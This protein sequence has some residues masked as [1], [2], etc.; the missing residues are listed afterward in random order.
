MGE[1][2]NGLF[3]STYSPACWSVRCQLWVGI[4]PSWQASS[5]P[6]IA[7][8][9]CGPPRHPTHS[10]TRPAHPPGWSCTR[11]ITPD[12]AQDIYGKKVICHCFCTVFVLVNLSETHTCL[13]W[14]LGEQHLILGHPEFLSEAG[15]PSDTTPPR[16]AHAHQVICC[17][18]Y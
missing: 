2:L 17:S 12:T 8:Q 5:W 18:S 11:D 13:L 9:R 15:A 7:W 1:W 14:H 3:C 10:H 16:H 4:C 6:G